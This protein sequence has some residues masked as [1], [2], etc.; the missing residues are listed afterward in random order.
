MLRVRDFNIV[1][2][3]FSPFR[4]AVQMRRRDIEE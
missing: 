1:C 4:K 3:H 2:R